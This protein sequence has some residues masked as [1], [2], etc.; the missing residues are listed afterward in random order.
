MVGR[1]NAGGGGEPKVVTGS[2]TANSGN[3]N[4]FSVSGI[5]FEPKFLIIKNT[6]PYAARYGSV[7]L[8]TAYSFVNNIGVCTPH[9]GSGYHRSPTDKFT[10][11][12]SK[13]GETLAITI[14]PNISDY[15]DYYFANNYTDSD[16]NNHEGTGTYTYYLYG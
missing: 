10:M 4:S 14:N 11:T 2:F 15:L 16:G 13:N 8:Y 3:V 9:N 5:S 6:N 7:N 12:T 1:T